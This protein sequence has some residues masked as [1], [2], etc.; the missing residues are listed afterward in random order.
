M[1]M[2]VDI[3]H[4][5]WKRNCYYLIENAIQYQFVELIE[6]SIESAEYLSRVLWKSEYLYSIVSEIK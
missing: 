1:K 6:T 2:Q 3:I 4:G 5:T